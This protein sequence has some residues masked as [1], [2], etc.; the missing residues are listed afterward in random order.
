MEDVKWL[1]KKYGF[2]IVLMVIIVITGSIVLGKRGSEKNA[3][4]VWEPPVIIESR[5]AVKEDESME[6]FAEESEERPCQMN[7]GS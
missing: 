4:E 7:A 2:F 3:E 5:E 6:C 1:I